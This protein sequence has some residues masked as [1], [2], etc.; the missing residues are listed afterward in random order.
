MNLLAIFDNDGTIC[1]TQEVEGACYAKAI[2]RVTG[3]SLATLDWTTYEEPTSSA[4]VREFLAGDPA[5]LEKEGEIECEFVRLLEQERPAFPGD[6]IPLPG[7]LQ[8]ISRLK[9]E[10]I[11]SVAIATGCFYA[12]A[13]FKLQCCGIALDDY[14]HATSSDTPRRRDIIP[15]AASR[16][17]FPLSSVVYFGDAPW[18]VRVSRTLGVAMI[19][20]GRRIQRLRELGVEYVFR[21]YSDS[22]AII[23]VLCDLKKEPNFESSVTP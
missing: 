13:R 4:I 8:F 15:L 19:G 22:D 6:F 17:G 12:S 9:E 20:I 10:S 7:V 11:C 21:D 18:D 5:A 14:P 2:E 1:D 23:R 16:A 3:R